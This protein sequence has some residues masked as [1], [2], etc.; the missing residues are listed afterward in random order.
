MDTWRLVG[1]DITF[2][3]DLVLRPVKPWTETV[4]ALLTH[5]RGVGL[6]CVPEPVGIRDGVE[7]VRFIPGDSG[8]A[9]WPHQVAVEGLESAAAMLR[10]V[11]DAR[12]S[13]QP[14][15][16]AEWMFQP[17]PGADVVCHGD[18]GPWNF[19][20][21]D[22]RA[23]ALIDWDQASPGPAMS[24][25]AYALD[26][27]VPFRPDDV[28]TTRHGFSHPPDRAAR[29]RAFAAAY[30]LGGTSGLVDRVIER[31]QRTLERVLELAER[32]LEPWAGWVKEGHLDELRARTRW[33]RAHRHLVE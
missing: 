18:P 17:V 15:R 8:A 9:A 3:D 32:G 29:M 24:D 14:P 11:H 22:G 10:R 1:G 4:H 33:T 26:S 2:V 19:V 20:W 7:A 30:G 13:F 5:L 28:A 6:D 16:H 12:A 23:V 25:V 31:Q 27:F 21:R